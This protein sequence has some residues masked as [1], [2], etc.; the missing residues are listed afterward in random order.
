MKSKKPKKP[1]KSKM[2]VIITKMRN[3]THLTKEEVGYIADATQ[4]KEGHEEFVVLIDD[5]CQCVI[6]EFASKKPE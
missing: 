4:T 3:G 5:W 2:A 6:K 1:K